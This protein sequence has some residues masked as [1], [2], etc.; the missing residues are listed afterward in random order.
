MTSTDFFPP[1][2]VDYFGIGLVT[3]AVLSFILMF[4]FRGKRRK[5]VVLFSL[6]FAS[7]SIYFWR[8]IIG[9]RIDNLY[10]DIFDCN[11]RGKGSNRLDFTKT[12]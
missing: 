4:I 9:Y 3:L 5:V 10:C 1:H 6:I 7:L 12:E 8:D 2:I 11:E